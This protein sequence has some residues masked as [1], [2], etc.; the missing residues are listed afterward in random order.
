MSCFYTVYIGADKKGVYSFHQILNDCTFK[1]KNRN[2]LRNLCGIQS[3]V[4]AEPKRSGVYQTIGEV[5]LDSS[6]L[7]TVCKDE[8]WPLNMDSNNS[9]K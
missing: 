7:N 5:Q 2:M 8:N 6:T 4:P 3:F 1:L 9:F